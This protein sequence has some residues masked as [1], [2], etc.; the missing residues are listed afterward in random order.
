[1]LQNFAHFQQWCFPGSRGN[2]FADS[3]AVPRAEAACVVCAQKDYLDHRHKLSLFETIPDTPLPP[4]AND[5]DD[6]E[7]D[8]DAGAGAAQLSRKPA[9]Q[10]MV[11]HRGIYYI[12]NEDKV[13]ALLNVQRY[14][15]RWPLIPKDCLLYTSDAADE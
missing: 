4:N 14:A 9:Q 11:K 3:K 12:Q 10:S 7:S 6:I 8:A 13:Q 15:D 5:S 2:Y 1:M